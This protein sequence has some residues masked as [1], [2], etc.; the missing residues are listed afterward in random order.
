MRER[1]AAATGSPPPS[2]SDVEDDDDVA[3]VATDAAYHDACNG[4]IHA[5]HSVVERHAEIRPMSAMVMT[6]CVAVR[7]VSRV[8][9]CAVPLIHHR[10]SRWVRDLADAYEHDPANEAANLR[11]ENEHLDVDGSEEDDGGGGGRRRRR[12]DDPSSGSRRRPQTPSSA[13]PPRVASPSST[14]DP[15]SPSAFPLP[16][17]ASVASA[18]PVRTCPS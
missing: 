15:A 8:A 18:D 10:F 17:T 2:V 11:W 3:T 5:L 7:P 1:T 13:P 4:Y 14:A 9:L 6:F 12:A 16:A